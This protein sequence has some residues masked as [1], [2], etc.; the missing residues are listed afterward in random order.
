[1]TVCQCPGAKCPRAWPHDL[2]ALGEQDLPEGGFGWFL[3][4]ELTHDLTYRRDGSRNHLSF[5]MVL[6]GTSRPN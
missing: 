2:E 3:I 5:R 6:G 4:R 1:M